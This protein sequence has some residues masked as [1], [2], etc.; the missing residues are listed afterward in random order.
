MVA[1]DLFGIMNVDS[2]NMIKRGIVFL[3]STVF[4]TLFSDCHAPFSRSQSHKPIAE[5]R[6]AV[7]FYRL[8]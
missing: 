7:T 8:F 3:I 2:E 4:L 1:N 5:L 6:S